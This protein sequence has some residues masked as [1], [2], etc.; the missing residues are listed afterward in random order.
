MTG[1]S[2]TPLSAVADM[3]LGKMLDAAKQATGRP[4]PYLRNINVRWY[5]FDLNDLLTMTFDV[6]EVYEFALRPGDLLIC[7]GGEPGRCAIWQQA[8]SAIKFQKAVHRVRLADGIDPR[9]VMYHLRYMSLTGGLD[10]YFTG[11]TIK[12]FTGVSLARYQLPVAPVAEQKRI[13]AK[14]QEALTR[15]NAARERLAKVPTILKRFRQSVLAAACSGRLTAD[16]RESNGTGVTGDQLVDQ[17][18]DA[19]RR[20]EA[21]GVL[22]E[23]TS[24]RLDRLG[25]L[26]GRTVDTAAL[27]QIPDSWTWVYLPQTGYMNRG[28]SRHRPRGAAHLYG[29]PHPFVQT[30]DIARSNGRIIRHEQ[31]YSD[32]GLEQSRLWPVGT[33]CIT[34]AANIANTAIL[35]YPACFPDSVV[36]LVTEPALLDNRFVE[37]FMRTARS[38]LA[39]YAP[40]TAQK[41]INVEILNEVAVPVPPRAEQSEIVLRVETMFDLADKIEAKVRAGR[42]RAEKLVQATL[43]K[44]FRGE[45]VPTEAELAEADGRE[46][47]TAKALLQRIRTERTPRLDGGVVTAGTGRRRSSAPRSSAVVS[48]L[49]FGGATSVVKG[50]RGKKKEAR[51]TRGTS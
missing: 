42:M 49:L 28:R 35:T 18:R 8:D 50:R 6:N 25:L 10:E 22:I 34:I 13:V 15:V 45:L 2:S 20:G 9:W 24:R 40:A 5:E 26:D 12:H 3:R 1:W 30:G 43:A 44:A 31:T 17:V 11:S 16:W 41:N 4:F 48:D 36:G 39:A 38:D 32:A 19:L 21:D 27:P 33:I 23:R 7:E 46:Y 37:F 51:G 29:G 47:E 14:V